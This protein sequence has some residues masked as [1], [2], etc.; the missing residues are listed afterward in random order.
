MI[1]FYPLRL[2][3]RISNPLHCHTFAPFTLLSCFFVLFKAAVIIGMM[4]TD[5]DDGGA[6]PKVDLSK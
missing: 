1:S 3:S 4:V 5:N 2:P 6:S